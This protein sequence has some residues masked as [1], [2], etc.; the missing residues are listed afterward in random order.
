VGA[1]WQAVDLRDAA[2]SRGAFNS[3]NGEVRMHSLFRG[4]AALLR[5]RRG[6]TALEYG[7]IA[8]WLAFVVIA[9]FVYLGQGLTTL[10][11]GVANSL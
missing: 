3:V 2:A 6:I 9:A 5:D 10:I 11:G 7:I 4:V 1:D 8:G